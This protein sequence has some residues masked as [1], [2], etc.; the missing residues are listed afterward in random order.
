MCDGGD[1]HVFSKG[2]AAV[3]SVV[4]LVASGLVGA[5]AA[6]AAPGD[7]LEVGLASGATPRAVAPG[8]DGNMWVTGGAS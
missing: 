8:P 5:S 6:N 3:I 2:L 1:M 7:V 4:A